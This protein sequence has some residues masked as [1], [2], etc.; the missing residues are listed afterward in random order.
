MESIKEFKNGRNETVKVFY[1]EDAI[2]PRK[3]FDY[4]TKVVTTNNY[5]FG[6][7]TQ[8]IEDI[9]DRLSDKSFMNDNIVLPIYAYIHS[10]MT[11]STTSFNDRWDSGQ[12]GYIFVSKETVRAE[13]NVSRISSRLRKRVINMMA[14]EISTEL[15]KF[16]RGEIYRFEVYNEN[17]ELIDS[18]SGFYSIEDIIEETK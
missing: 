8:S 7:E 6:D 15:D 1:D 2:S 9:K 14:S 18:C 17:D 16:V 11:I 5:S 12:I 3:D 13:Y 10:G 4:I